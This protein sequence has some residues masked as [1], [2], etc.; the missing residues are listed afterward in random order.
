MQTACITVL[1]Y[2]SNRLSRL[3]WFGGAEGDIQKLRSIIFERAKSSGAPVIPP[4]AGPALE[5]KAV[6]IKVIGVKK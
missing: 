2:T 4:L 6:R 5:A 1:V 3:F